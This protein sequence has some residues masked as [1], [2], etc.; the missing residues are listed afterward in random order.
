MVQGERNTRLG[1]RK[2]G[3]KVLTMFCTWLILIGFFI[4]LAI[5]L[6]IRLLELPGAVIVH[7]NSYLTLE[8]IAA[9]SGL[10][11]MG[12]FSPVTLAEPSFLLCDCVYSTLD[13][14]DVSNWSAF[15]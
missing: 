11:T 7:F 1:L 8:S 2:R 15:A 14:L 6:S 12:G 3:V 9:S 5:S 13:N 10:A 4:F